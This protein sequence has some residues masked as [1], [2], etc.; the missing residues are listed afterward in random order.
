MRRHG[1]LHGDLEYPVI[2]A[3][4]AQSLEM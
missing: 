3:R 4:L 1:A 2:D